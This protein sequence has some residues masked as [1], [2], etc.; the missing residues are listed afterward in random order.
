MTTALLRLPA[1]RQ[2]TGLSRSEIYRRMALRE[3]PAKVNLGPRAVG[4]A[5]DEITAWIE[6]R[7]HQSRKAV[8]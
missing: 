2:R 1:V 3:F 6:E 7:I 5:E 8:A 4:W